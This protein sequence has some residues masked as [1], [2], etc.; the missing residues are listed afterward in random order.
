MI[1][2]EAVK[3]TALD[4]LAA[5]ND[6]LSRDH[7]TIWEMAEPAWREYRSAAWYVERLRAAGWTVEEGSAT[8]PTAF[9]ATW[10]NEGPV[11]GLRR[12]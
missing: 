4:W 10:G 9:C 11:L 5:N 3:Q 7:L 2:L 8:M 12:V 6:Q 1:D